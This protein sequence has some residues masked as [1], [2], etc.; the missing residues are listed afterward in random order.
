MLLQP[1]YQKRDQQECYKS[2]PKKVSELEGSVEDLPPI[3]ICIAPTDD[4]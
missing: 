1:E 2:G 4:C 3:P